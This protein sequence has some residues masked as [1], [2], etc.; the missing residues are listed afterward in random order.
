MMEGHNQWGK[1]GENQ[2]RQPFQPLTSP[3]VTIL[4]RKTHH[5]SHLICKDLPLSFQALLHHHEIITEVYDTSQRDAA[6]SLLLAAF[7]RLRPPRP[8]RV[9]SGLSSTLYPCTTTVPSNQE[10]GRPGRGLLSHPGHYWM[11]ISHYSDKTIHVWGKGCR[12]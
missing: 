7:I 10:T 12:L 5:N 9:H 11:D 3:D 8:A 1:Y 2:R 4:D 6:S